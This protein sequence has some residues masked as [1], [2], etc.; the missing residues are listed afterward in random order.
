M[1][2]NILNQYTASIVL[3][4]NPEIIN[5]ENLK[6]INICFI[7]E[8]VKKEKLLAENNIKAD[9]ANTKPVMIGFA[10]ASGFDRATKAIEL[11][12]STLLINEKLVENNKSILLL[13]SSHSKGI[14]IDEIGLINDYIQEK[15]SYKANI[16]MMISEDENLGEALAITV[17]L[18]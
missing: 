8:F 4:C 3:E 15:S 5:E 12:F 13:I 6:N 9:V 16:V 7:D 2:T 14:S 17:V 18:S 1:K 10:I 11:A